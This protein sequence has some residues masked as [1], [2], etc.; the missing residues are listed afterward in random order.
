MMQ[1]ST[2]GRIQ[3]L[4]RQV[5]TAG[6]DTTLATECLECLLK[7]EYGDLG[8]ISRLLGKTTG[9][10]D[11][12]S[13]SPDTDTD[14]YHYA[15]KH[16]IIH[17]VAIP[18]P[19][20]RLVELTVRFLT[21]VQFCY[22]A[23]FSVKDPGDIQAIRSADYDLRRWS[24]S[25][26]DSLSG[27]LK[28]EEYFETPYTTLHAQYTNYEDDELPQWLTL[29]RLGAY[30]FDQGSTSK[31]GDVR[32]RAANGLAQLLGKC[33]PTTLQARADAAYA[34]LLK[35]DALKAHDIYVHVAQDQQ[36]FSKGG[37]R[38][39]YYKTLVSQG[40]AEYLMSKYTSAL[41][42]LSRSSSW[43][44]QE[45]GDK[46]NYYLTAHLWQSL[47]VSAKNGL[48]EAIKSLEEIREKREQ[49]YGRLDGF[50]NTVRIILGDLYRRAGSY[51]Q[52][53]RNAES[54]LH[55]RE[56]VR[57]FSHL[58]V[59]DAALRL[60]IVYRHFGLADRALKLLVKVNDEGEI[61]QGDKFVQL[62]QVRHL[63]SLLLYEGREVSKAIA[64]LYD[65]V[66][67]LD[68][69]QTNR[70]I[71]WA[72]L[73]LALMMRHRN[74]PGDA[75]LA[76]LLFG[77][78]VIPQVDDDDDRERDSDRVLKLAEKALLTF[79]R[80]SLEEAERLL[81]EEGMTWSR[82]EFLWLPLG[83]PAA[84][85]TWIAEP[86]MNDSTQRHKFEVAVG[87]KE[88]PQMP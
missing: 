47:V 48:E 43:F 79:R 52:S 70:A 59:I 32:T 49:R 83:M 87:R 11:P 84:D 54:G 25:L 26:P 15:A 35:G 69:R 20:A 16:W 50:A 66:T 28:V 41:A 67:C 36:S 75:E 46:S 82:P 18:L 39:S 21:S 62:C 55:F 88:R 30:Y 2:I 64:Q 71:L 74:A 1:D 57:P 14:F 80:E 37:S 76:H 65:F 19:S 6:S 3:L 40:Q 78:L 60:V 38:L 8:R 81:H 73:D 10:G 13:Q 31:M 17:L 42:T 7:P 4:E 63:H 77:G 85:T 72:L 33:N 86:G 53:I 56:Q 23:E 44:L 24:K 58:A 45:K 27:Q 12:V 51:D 22:W 29:M 61:N 9:S 68:P 5:A 34:P